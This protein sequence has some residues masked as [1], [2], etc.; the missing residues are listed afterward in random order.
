MGPKEKQEKQ[1][2]MFRCCYSGVRAISERTSAVHWPC[3]VRSLY[4][5]IVILTVNR[6]SKLCRHVDLCVVDY[7]S[8]SAYDNHLP[9]A[10]LIAENGFRRRPHGRWNAKYCPPLKREVARATW[11]N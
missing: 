10:S 9:P 11:S 8:P 3:I 1:A 6:L 7:R 5:T 4:N 2:C